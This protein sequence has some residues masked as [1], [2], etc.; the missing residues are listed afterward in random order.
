MKVEFATTQVDWD[1]QSD[2]DKSKHL[3]HY[4]ETLSGMVTNEALVK[5]VLALRDSVGPNFIT[6]WEPKPATA[7]KGEKTAATGSGWT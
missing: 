3:H 4:D 1:N 2:E 7:E 5:V 6:P